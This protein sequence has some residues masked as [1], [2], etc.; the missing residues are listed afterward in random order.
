MNCFL[1]DVT[2]QGT[3]NMT[4]ANNAVQIRVDN[5]TYEES[6]DTIVS[7]NWSDRDATKQG[8]EAVISA[9]IKGLVCFY[10]TGLALDEIRKTELFKP[11]HKNFYAYCY[12]KFKLSSSR[13]KQLL[14]AIRVSDSVSTVVKKHNIDLNE[15]ICRE[16]FKIKD[17][18]RRSQALE[19]A[20]K[21]GSVTAKSIHANYRNITLEKSSKRTNPTLPEVGAVVRLNTNFNPELDHLKGYWGIVSKQYNY[22][23]SV[24]VLGANISNIHPQEFTEIKDINR[25]F[26]CNILERINR[27]YSHPNANELL[28]TIC[29]AIGS[30]PYP[31]LDDY[32]FRFLNFIE[33][34]LK[35]KSNL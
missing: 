25:N 9:N 2:Q 32:D 29:I 19:E 28:R 1:G 33:I 4:I 8:L 3:H 27:I 14:R 26:S 21:A 17:L 22:T 5:N 31:S 13:V 23:V 10:D 18:D 7:T 34:E 11:E 30:R 24:N 16:L 12:Q 15:G 35:I 6:M 20:A